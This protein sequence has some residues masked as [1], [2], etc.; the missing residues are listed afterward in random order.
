MS[1]STRRISVTSE[2]LQ[3]DAL[4]AQLFSACCAYGVVEW[5]QYQEDP[6][7]NTTT[8]H[9][10]F[11]KLSS[12]DR[13]R[14]DVQ[15]R[16]RLWQIESE[17]AALCVGTDVLLSAAE[18]L[19]LG[20]LTAALPGFACTALAGVPVRN[21]ST[22]AT[23]TQTP[24]LP[25]FE[26][27]SF[28]LH[29]RSSASRTTPA[30]SKVTAEQEAALWSGFE[31]ESSAV[32]HSCLGPYC[33]VLHFGSPHD[34]NE[35]LCQHQLTLAE[36]HSV[37]AIHVGTAPG[38]ALAV[39]L[40]KMLA[41]HALADCA[42]DGRV[43]RGYVVAMH[44]STYCVVDAGLYQSADQ[45]SITTLVHTH[46]NFLSVS[47]GDEVQV[48]LSASGGLTMAEKGMVGGKLL[49]VT[50]TSAFSTRRSVTKAQLPDTA[51][52]TLRTSNLA[53]GLIGATSSP[54]QPQARPASGGRAT[55]VAGTV[56]R[57]TLNNKLNA[58]VT[59]G[60]NGGAVT[61]KSAGGAAAKV[62]ASKLFRSIQ[63]RKSSGGESE[64]SS[65]E[66]ICA[67][68]AGLGAYAR[69]LV[70][71]E[72]IE[73]DGLHA[74]CV[75]DAENC[76]YAGP[77]F[78]PAA[79]VP[80]DTSSTGQG[81]RTFAVVGERMH[82]ALLYMVAVG[83]S[84]ATMRGVASKKEADLRHTAATAVAAAVRVTPGDVEGASVT[85]GTTVKATAMLKL[86]AGDLGVPAA[87]HTSPY[88]PAFL[89]YPG[90]HVP[91]S[92]RQTVLLLPL[93]D[94][95][96]LDPTSLST[97]PGFLIVSEVVNDV[98]RGQYAVVVPCAVYA[99]RQAQ[100]AV[101]QEQRKTAEVDEVKRRLAAVMGQDILKVLNAE[102]GAAAKRP[103]AED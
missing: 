13:L 42:V 15:Q 85:A 52:R 65:A 101:A 68:P 21:T 24:S 29:G 38:C 47:L 2:Q 53:H 83:G 96:S 58:T 28:L 61:S 92:L 75:D 103:R 80:A 7:Y 63:Q 1:T 12:A 17:P 60:G 91:A 16:G 50:S 43:V 62:L 10:Q 64:G 35:F 27:K 82:V 23:V 41:R 49:R 72:R 46:T 56:R 67:Y 79:F 77:V 9:I 97:T 4:R 86:Y 5:A 6:N 59:G 93:S 71:V 39:A 89:L 30:S 95:G 81:W 57:G 88:F 94:L 98:M 26:E 54:H 8:V 32:R 100:R 90:L 19:R 22:A 25:T 55:D 74:R 3:S 18:V 87:D 36:Q 66:R 73:Q 20:R 69:L 33:A 45:A 51:A 76:G 99:A 78:I 11:Q 34:A 37:Y 31:Q 48:Q 44:S 40:P 84:A 14:S 102:D 70:R